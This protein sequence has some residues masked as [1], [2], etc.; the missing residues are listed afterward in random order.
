MMAWA[1]KTVGGPYLRGYTIVRKS[2]QRFA[3]I[4]LSII[5]TLQLLCVAVTLWTCDSAPI[6]GTTCSW[7]SGS[8]QNGRARM[9]PE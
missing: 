2:A 7:L 3:N 6:P 1:L 5:L 4:R 8:L 9:A